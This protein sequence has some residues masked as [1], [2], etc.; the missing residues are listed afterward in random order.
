[1]ARQPGARQPVAKRRPP[2][3]PADPVSGHPPLVDQADWS[4][5]II[6]GDYSLGEAEEVEWTSCRFDHAA[7]TGLLL[8]KARIIDCVF[9][10][11]ELSGALFEDATLTRVEFRTC[12][13][14]GLQA[15][16]V[17]GQDVGFFDCRLDGANLR[18][19][20]WERA[21]WE[22]CDLH[23]GDLYAASAPDA[24]L[25]ACDLRCAEISKAN[26]AGTRLSAS[27]IEGIRGGES[28]RGVVLSSDQLIPAA[29]AVFSALGIVVDDDGPD[30]RS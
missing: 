20:T 7:L 14:S 10:D 29:L 5:L 17:R 15:P 19:S 3:N 9:I 23:D 11:C 6:E 21:E 13:M 2:R 27:N 12:R 4:D 16:G 22:R 1:V 25:I 18:M 24:R 26:L 30:E 8:P 28:L